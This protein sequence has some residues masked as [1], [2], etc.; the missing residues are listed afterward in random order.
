MDTQ[1]QIDALD[2]AIATGILTVTFNSRT[3]TYQSISDLL[4][5]RALIAG[6]LGSNQPYRV[7]QTNK[8]G[9]STE[10]EGE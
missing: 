5:A 1:A 10:N 9:A 8:M 7:A 6:R 2:A 3:V 4:K